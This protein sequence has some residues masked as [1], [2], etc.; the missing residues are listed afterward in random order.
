MLISILVENSD[1]LYFDGDV[2]FSGCIGAEV[3]DLTYS[4]TVQCLF[5]QKRG[6]SHLRVSGGGL[7]FRWVCSGLLRLERQSQKLPHRG[8]ID[9]IF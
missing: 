5:L 7:S 2:I 9:T 6:E 3:K 4:P 1:Q 8:K